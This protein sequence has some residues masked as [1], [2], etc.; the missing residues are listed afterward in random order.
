MDWIAGAKLLADRIGEVP[1]RH[2]QVS[3]DASPL[4]HWCGVDPEP[5][6]DPSQV[7]QP[8]EAL[9]SPDASQTHRG[10][11][12]KTRFLRRLAVGE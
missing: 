4:F 3:A 5:A 8:G 11:R 10:A 2:E 1:D 9:P 12:K 6:P 7:R